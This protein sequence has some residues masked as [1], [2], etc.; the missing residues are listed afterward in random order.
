MF[1]TK[2]SIGIAVIVAL[3]M[4]AMFH[5]YRN[6]GEVA[7]YL[8]TLDSVSVP[9]SIAALEMEK[10][11]GEYADG[12][13]RYIHSPDPDVRE[14]AGWD[15]GDFDER[16]EVYMRLSTNDQERSLGLKVKREHEKLTAAGNALMDQRDR[17]DAVFHEAT[18]QLERI[19]ALLDGRIPDAAPRPRSGYAP[20]LVALQNV[21]A[22][23]AEVGFWL[24]LFR[25][26]PSPVNSKQ[27]LEKI[28]EQ[29]QA[30]SQYL[31]L[32]LDAGERELGGAINA[33]HNK[34]AVNARTL[35]I[36]ET[37]LSQ[38]EK[39]L[40]EQ[41]NLIDGIFDDEIQTMLMTDLSAP[42]ANANEAVQH[43]QDTL[44]YV[45]PAYAL[46]AL[47]VGLLLILAIIRPLRRLADG[48]EALGAGDLE[49]R[50]HV[51]GNDEFAQLGRQF[52][53][54]AE[55]LQDSTVSRGLLEA[56]EK[57]LQQTVAELRQ[58]I[59][60]RQQA[61]RE[62]E[63]L[64][65]QLRHSETLAA[66][67]RLVAGVAHEVRNPLFGIS[68][69]LDAME[70]SA[71]TGR[72]NPRYREVLRREAERLNK[73]MADLLDF[74]R[75][76]PADRT[77]EPLRATLAE[78]IRNCQPSADAAGVAVADRSS[79]DAPVRMHRDRLLQ[80][81]VNLIENALQHAPRDSEV[82]ITTRATT[83]DRKQ[84]WIE[85]CV[86]D[87]GPGFAPGDLER[88]FEP[89]FTRRRKGTGLGLA[90]VRR[91]V[92]EH[93]GTIEAGNRP[94]GGAVMTVRLP[95]ADPDA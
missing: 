81:H 58:E 77:V 49:Y 45:I 70:A 26:R 36:G 52:N 94:E 24:T 90:I 82:V 91:I 12:V 15:S 23:T 63:K 51:H 33:L 4:L 59:T 28:G 72:V 44:L 39:A 6:L 75:T 71:E 68:S 60:E 8:A 62:R 67:G 27:L 57:Q 89:F 85:Y 46:I 1:K 50:I 40:K 16:Y 9:F 56:S 20:V 93:H 21:E 47:V 35:L 83:D 41:A 87:S 14:E 3:G 80:V 25:E 31:N 30:V 5:I 29:H 2:I 66:M 43:V 95:V 13:L 73:L 55:R 19:D 7:G 61:E 79:D 53:L 34:V 86:T 84:R 11:A 69:T 10:N 54:M 37:D 88:V 32:S 17:L 48:T 22:E 74:G 38:R 64:Q 18:G 65:G 92:D 78:A 76:P 42:Q